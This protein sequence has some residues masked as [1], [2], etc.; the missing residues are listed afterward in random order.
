MKATGRKS[1][2]VEATHERLVMTVFNVLQQSSK[3][4]KPTLL[5]Y[6]DLVVI[7]LT[8]SYKRI[9]NIG[10]VLTVENLFT[11]QV[12]FN[13]TCFLNSAKTLCIKCQ[14]QGKTR[15]YGILAAVCFQTHPFSGSIPSNWP[16]GSHTPSFL[17]KTNR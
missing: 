2:G 16:E 17:S 1:P 10:F 8:V 5:C 14:R 13:P 11:C 6:F 9:L 12:H 3:K 4:K 7:I 15:L